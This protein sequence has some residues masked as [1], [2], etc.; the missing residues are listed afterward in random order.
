MRSAVNWALLGLVIERP[1]YG[2]E[3]AQRFER[4]YGAVLSLSSPSHVYAALDALTKRSY[5]EEFARGH[6]ARQPRPRYRA[7]AAG[8]HHYEEW[9]VQ[10][11]H[12]ERRRQRLL[13]LQLTAVRRLPDATRILDRYEDALR[14]QRP[15]GL[16]AEEDAVG[17]SCIARLLSEEQRLMSEANLAWVQRARV[18]LQNQGS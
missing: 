2:Y 10:Q 13:V 15:E 12:E 18:E 4:S 3:L 6:E 14:A 17:P 11:A 1:G 16:P 7:T 9:L 8:L 5:V